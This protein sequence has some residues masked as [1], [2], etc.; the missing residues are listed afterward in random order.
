[1]YSEKIKTSGGLFVYDS[2]ETN[3]LAM[4]LLGA[5]GVSCLAC[6]PGTGWVAS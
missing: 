4:L 6:L 1:M 2:S 5:L 3:P